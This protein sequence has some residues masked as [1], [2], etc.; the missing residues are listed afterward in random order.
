M[1][2]MEVSKVIKSEML[3]VMPEPLKYKAEVVALSYAIKRAI[4]KMVGYA[5]RASVYAAI[6]KLPEDILDL[7]AVELRAQYYDEDMDISIKRE[8]VKKTMLWYHRAGTPSAVEELISAVFG[9]GE[10]SEW[11]E[12]GGEPYHFKIKTDAVLSASD[13]EYFEKIIRNVKNVRSHLE[14][15]QLSREHEGTA[16]AGCYIIN[17]GRG[18]VVEDDI[19]TAVEVLREHWETGTSAT[20][21]ITMMR[22]YIKE[23]DT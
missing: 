7:L 9:E 15:I 2:N 20:A 1:L 5:E 16:Y 10:I 11:F 14:E 13:M 4:G 23:E 21:A 6:D 8:I 17:N 18:C 12:Y 22:N 3:Q 19:D